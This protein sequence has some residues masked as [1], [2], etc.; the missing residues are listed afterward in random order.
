MSSGGGPPTPGDVQVSQQLRDLLKEIQVESEE[1]AKAYSK[2]GAAV[3]GTSRQLTYE[4]QALTALIKGKEAEVQLI[5]KQIEANQGNTQAIASLNAELQRAANDLDNYGRQLE[6]ARTL[7][8]AASDGFNKISRTLGIASDSTSNFLFQLA[9]L[10]GKARSATGS[11]RKA[12]VTVKAAGIAFNTAAAY[13]EQGFL[14]AIGKAWQQMLAIDQA[15]VNF[16]RT[17]GM[18]SAQLQQYTKDINKIYRANLQAGV[19]IDKIGQ[20]YT[21]L[22]G[23]MT[24]FSSMSNVT[25]RNLAE[26]ASLLERSGVSV[27]SLAQSGQV[28]N[29]VLG[30]TGQEVA[31]SQR[32]LFAFAS[33]LGRPPAVVQQEYAE[34]SMDMAIYGGKMEQ[35]FRELQ[36][37]VKD[38]GLSM[39]Q[40]MAV[41]GQFDT[42]D[43][44]AQAAGRLNAVLGRDLFNSLDMLL[45]TDPTIRFQ[46]LREGILEAA[47][48]FEQME[49]YEKRAIA[50]AA[51]LQGV[52]ELALLMSGNMQRAQMATAEYSLTADELAQRQIT[53]MSLQ[54]QFKATLQELAPDLMF[55]LQNMKE[56]LANLRDLI[57]VIKENATVIGSLYLGIKILGAAMPALQTGLMG[58]RMAAAGTATA[59]SGLTAAIGIGTGVGLIAALGFLAYSIFKKR[60]SPTIYEGFQQLPGMVNRTTGALGNLTGAVSNTAGAMGQLGQAQG[61]AMSVV[62]RLNRVKTSKLDRT[63]SAIRNIANAINQVDTSKSMN[64]NASLNLMASAQ[65]SQLVSSAVRLKRDNVQMVTDI[66]EQARLLSSASNSANEDQ[67]RALVASVGQLVRSVQAGSGGGS[68]SSYTGPSTVEATLKLDGY[69]LDTHILRLVRQELA[70]QSGP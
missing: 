63:A 11:M 46:K 19:S 62:D 25:Q 69:V 17:M 44:A 68:G 10:A 26:T 29:K 50:S 48:A 4:N 35:T 7:N 5:S 49:Y 39:N 23:T 8:A 34:M 32:E 43:G 6:N 65:M 13:I 22:Y 41:T 58:V 45:T 67:L 12:E 36:T 38:T 14:V 16:S 40:L 37:V 54:E 15:A 18:T 27:D 64:F 30:M 70:R 52:G 57:P 66:V 33:A 28:L 61:L 9:A 42:F 1:A 59:F 55:I 20:S 56:W 53:M 47:G 31:Q 51:G 21:T 2:L 60:S 3:A 24:E